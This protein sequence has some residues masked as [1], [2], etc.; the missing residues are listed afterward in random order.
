MRLAHLRWLPLAVL[1]T[2]AAVPPPAI[3]SPEGEE[4]LA[5]AADAKTGDVESQRLLLDEILHAFEGRVNIPQPKAWSSAYDRLTNSD[6][7]AIRDSADRVAVLLGDKR[8]FPRLRETLADD[9]AK[10]PDRQRALEILVRGRDEEAAGV[11]Q[12]VLDVP[13]LRGAAIR[14]LSAHA[15]PK[16]PQDQS[17]EQGRRDRVAPEASQC[18]IRRHARQCRINLQ[19]IGERHPELVSGSILVKGSVAWKMDAETSSA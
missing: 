13:A 1:A 10:L 17:R 9:K 19:T 5:E 6:D 4:V 12:E 18:Q 15:D 2:F 7:A 8:V 14:A 16:T 11:L 3:A